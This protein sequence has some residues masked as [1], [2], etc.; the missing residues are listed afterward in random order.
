MSAE[1]GGLLLEMGSL[2]LIRLPNLSCNR[3][4]HAS[5]HVVCITAQTPRLPKL[6]ARSLALQCCQVDPR[7]LLPRLTLALALLHRPCC[8]AP[9]ISVNDADTT[10]TSTT[11]KVTPPSIGGELQKRQKL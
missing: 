6:L 5:C 2:C 8:S 10:D 3:M 1:E 11:A 9:G 7:F 4:V